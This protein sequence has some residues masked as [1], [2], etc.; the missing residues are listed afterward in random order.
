MSFYREIQNAF[1]D[2]MEEVFKIMFTDSVFFQFMDEER[3]ATNVY[4]ESPEKVYSEPAYSLVGKVV[5][6]TEHGEEPVSTNNVSCV[7]TIPTKQLIT[8]QIPRVTEED[9]KKLEKG[10]FTFKGE[11]YLIDSVN[12][13][14]LVAD[15]WQFYEFKCHKD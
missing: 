9:L 6:T 15:E 8:N 2:G 10:I 12:P 14:T 1:L 4:D 11:K 7:I 13:K 5:L 3:T